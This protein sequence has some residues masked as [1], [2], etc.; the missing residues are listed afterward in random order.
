MA[1]KN[2]TAQKCA[3]TNLSLLVAR[4]ARAAATEHLHTA[5]VRGRCVDRLTSLGIHRHRLG[6]RRWGKG[7]S[8][9]HKEGRGEDV[10]RVRNTVFDGLKLDHDLMGV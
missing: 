7:K 4:H 1:P 9:H 5:A 6:V 2:Q 10:G 8:H 3:L